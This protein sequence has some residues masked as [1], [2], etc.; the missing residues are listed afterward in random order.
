MKT[1]GLI[2]IFGL[3]AWSWTV[4]YS[5]NHAVSEQTMIEIQNGLQDQI[6]KVM[7]SQ[8][9][10][11]NNIVFKK[12]WTKELSEEKVQAQF[13]IAFDEESEDSVNKIERK[14]SVI[15]VKL[16]ESNNEQ[17]WVVDSIKIEG[18]SIEFEEGLKFTSSTTQE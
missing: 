12:F 17:V 3:M 10:N 5:P 2:F 1:L 16:D 13:L 15:L 6:L 7:T 4:F 9:Q 18:E 8:S 14:G 11:L